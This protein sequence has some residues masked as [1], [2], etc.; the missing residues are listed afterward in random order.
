VLEER[1][2]WTFDAVS[3]SLAKSKAA[4]NPSAPSFYKA[5]EEARTQGIVHFSLFGPVVLK[6]A[7]PR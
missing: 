5:L 3:L 1:F 7:V 4:T 6:K 2:P